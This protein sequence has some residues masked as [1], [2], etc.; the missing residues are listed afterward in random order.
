MQ[1]RVTY[2][3][4]SFLEM[5]SV[6]RGAAQNTLMAYKADLEEFFA[7]IKEKHPDEKMDSITE[8]DILPYIKELDARQLSASTRLRRLSAL[9]QYF[10]FLLNE[11]H[12][13][14]N[15]LLMLDSPRQG[16]SIPKILHENE[17][18]ALL[19]VTNGMTGPDGTRARCLLELLYATGMRVS[20]L[21]TLSTLT[22]LQA[23]QAGQLYL[24]IKGKGGKERI[25]PLSDPS[26]QA[27][28][29]YLKVRH[30][31]E[32]S[33]SSSK[34]SS[35]LFP[36]KSAKGHLTRQGFGKI[37]KEITLK[38]GLDPQRV[39]PHVLRHAFATHLLDRGADLVSVQQLLGHADV[40]TTEIY[41]HV[42]TEKMERLVLERHPLS[43][44]AKQ[45]RT[46][47]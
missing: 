2:L 40:S 38:A 14:H 45:A 28:R 23:L 30:V 21:V 46:K 7:F 5:L 20:E 1:T 10:K 13:Q 26:L 16:R 22:V 3:I 15:P 6:E 8:E 11:G 43:R 32:P 41:T 39:S 12:I 17:V 47:R 24:I 33:S 9:R 27:I 4:E 36:S 29:S 31:F 18:F 44:R 37:L 25:V 19:E 42:M 34:L 35:W